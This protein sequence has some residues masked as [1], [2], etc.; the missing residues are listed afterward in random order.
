MGLNHLENVEK[1]VKH[2]SKMRA[3]CKHKINEYLERPMLGNYKPL[4][5]YNGNFLTL[6]FK[7]SPKSLL[8]E[9]VRSQHAK[10]GVC[11]NNCEMVHRVAINKQNNLKMDILNRCSQ[12]LCRYTSKSKIQPGRTCIEKSMKLCRNLNGTND[13]IISFSVK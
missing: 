4:Y 11:A 10:I 5:H 7:M 1:K 12:K 6:L 13:D 2:N 8:P 3:W 9:L